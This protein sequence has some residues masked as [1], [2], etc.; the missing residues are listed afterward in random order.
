MKRTL[1]LN[2]AA[3]AF[4]FCSNY[5]F[6]ADKSLNVDLKDPSGN[7]VGTANLTESKGGVRVKADVKG[8]PPG[9]K[10]IHV[11]EKGLCEGP[12]FETA[13]SH[14]NPTNTQHGALNSDGSHLGDLPNLEVKADG[15]GKLDHVLKGATLA[16]GE[17][18]LRKP[19]GTAIVIHAGPDD[20][21]T[22]PSGKSGDRIACGI[23]P[24]TK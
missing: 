6:S 14:Y 13:G 16:T 23:I 3:S 10:G 24:E 1:A 19:G 15:Q 20:L 11:H 17:K 4:L 12:K 7:K 8:L 21:A 2:L 18:S 5:S 22:N 9:L